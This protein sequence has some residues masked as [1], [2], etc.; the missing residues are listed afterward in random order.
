[1]TRPD[2]SLLPVCSKCEAIGETNWP[3]GWVLGSGYW[4]CAD[5]MMKWLRESGQLVE[6]DA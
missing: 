4:I 2:F 3:A 5:C 1:V 6:T